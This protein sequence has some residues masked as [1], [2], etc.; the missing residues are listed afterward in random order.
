M[1]KIVWIEDDVETVE[2]FGF[3]LGEEGYKVIYARNGQSGIE[4]VSLM[5]PDIILLDIKLPDIDGFEICRILKSKQEYKSIPI[6]MMTGMGDTES[7][8]Q[9]LSAGADD[10]VSKPPNFKEFLARVKSHLKMKE[11][12]DTVKSEEEDKSAILDV[13]K[14]LSA[15]T[16]PHETLYTICMKI[17]EVMDVKRCSIIYVDNLKKEAYVMASHDSREIKRLEINLDKYPEIQKVM[18][19]GNAVVINDVYNDPI[20]FSVREVLSLIDIKS[21][22]AFPVVFKDTII[23]T[24]VLRTSRREEPFNAREIRFCEVISHLA[25]P[26]LKNAYLFDVLHK[27]KEQEKEKRISAE[28]KTRKLSV[29]VEQSPSTIII[30]DTNGIIEY[31][32]SSFTQ[33]TGYAAKEAIGQNPRIFKSGKTS[34]EEYERLWKT[35]TSGDKWRGRFCNKKKDGTLYW[36]EA[37]ISSLKNEGGDIT[38]YIAVKVDITDRKRAEEELIKITGE[39]RERNEELEKFHRITVGR[40]LDMIKLKKM[41][42]TLLEELGRPKEYEVA[43]EET[44]VVV[45]LKDI[46]DRK[47]AEENLKTSYNE[48]KATQKA[49]LNIM[50]D[51]CRRRSELAVALEEKEVLLKE[52]H[53]RVKNNMQIVSSLLKFQSENIKESQYIEM[54]NECRNRIQAMS[55]IH[56]KLYSSKD[57]ASINFKDYVEDLANNLFRFYK[58]S[59]AKI[60]LVIDV[61]DVTFNIETSIPCGLII[62]EFIS[63]SLKYAF[64][65]NREGE[66]KISLH[67]IEKPKVVLVLSDNG[68][69]IPDDIDFRNTKS[70]GLRLIVNLSERQLDGKIELDRSNG[71]E[72]KIVFEELKYKDRIKYT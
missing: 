29:A 61:A 37:T 39:L 65:D 71:T 8:V 35:L 34:P 4:M 3:A 57:T 17:A 22:M 45:S 52:I 2:P 18:E 28:E 53:H 21:I 33:L 42:N 63:N 26:P 16:D 40:E 23:G 70:L 5:K 12:Y 24:L 67:K 31:V 66:I 11:L 20:L 69:C 14:A 46:T 9:G 1:K 10:F 58:V 43:E 68:I 25:A 56:E 36:E 59:P 30:T 48:L 13:S 50:E 72:F 6:I 55:L 7:A 62:N 60:K 64:P 44:N 19:T 41:V 54:F 38:H 49:S 47:R 27:E 15:T 51:L 32:N